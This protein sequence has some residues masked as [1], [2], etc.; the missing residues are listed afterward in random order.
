MQAKAQGAADAVKNATGMKWR[1]YFILL[2]CQNGLL[3]FRILKFMFS[4]QIRDA[5]SVA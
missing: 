3:F 4:F 2:G 1:S 5:N